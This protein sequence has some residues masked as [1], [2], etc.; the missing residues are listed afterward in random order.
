[1]TK[2]I[3]KQ[4][5][6]LLDSKNI[7]FDTKLLSRGPNLQQ[8]RLS[9]MA[10]YLRIYRSDI[11]ISGTTRQNFIKFTIFIPYNPGRFATMRLFCG[12]CRARSAC[13]YVQSDLALHSPLFLSVEEAPIRYRLTNGS[14]FVL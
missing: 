5:D 13:T 14:P 3:F 9:I 6:L 11:G 8:N 4:C 2:K 7:Y 1:M 12:K 10:S